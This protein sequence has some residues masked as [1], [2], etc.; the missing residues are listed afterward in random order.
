[1]TQDLGYIPSNLTI[2]EEGRL[3]AEAISEDIL[4]EAKKSYSRTK[5]IDTKKAS[6]VIGELSNRFKFHLK[7]IKKNQTIAF[8]RIIEMN[9]K[10]KMP[11]M[12][13]HC[14]VAVQPKIK[15]QGRVESFIGA[16]N[17][18]FW[19]FMRHGLIGKNFS[20]TGRGNLR[21]RFH[22]SGKDPERNGMKGSA[23]TSLYNKTYNTILRRAIK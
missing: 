1:M 20:M 14:V 21:E 13:K 16:H 3:I 22:R 23:K 12:I 17:I 5:S 4:V 15:S 11:V 10:K 18:C 9:N 2:I 7:M 8:Q 6:S 19:S